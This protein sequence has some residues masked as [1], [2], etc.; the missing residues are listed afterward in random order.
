VDVLVDGANNVGLSHL[1]RGEAS[2]YVRVAPDTYA[3]DLATSGELVSVLSLSASND[4]CRTVLDACGR[5]TVDDVHADIDA[6]LDDVANI[7]TTAVRVPICASCANS[8]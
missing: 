6:S 5:R 2:E 8:R 3:L 1:S 7:A 4:S